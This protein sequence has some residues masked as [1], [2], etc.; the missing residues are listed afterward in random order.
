[1]PSPLELESIGDWS[2]IKGTEYHFV[3]ALWLLLYKKVPTVAFYQG[4]DL[5]VRPVFPPTLHNTASLV[6]LRVQQQNESEE[7]IWIQLK[8]T[9]K[10]WT[11]RE[12]QQGNLLANFLYNALLSE[13]ERRA[14]RIQLITQAPVRVEKVQDFLDNPT[15]HPEFAKHIEESI[16]EVQQNWFRTFQCSVE[17]TYLSGLLSRVLSQLTQTRPVHLDVLKAQIETQIACQ[18]PDPVGVREIAERLLGALLVDSARGPEQATPYTAQWIDQVVSF[19]LVSGTLLT[20]EPIQAATDALQASLPSS[21]NTRSFIAR[22]LADAAL[23]QFLSS[24]KTLFVLIG[25]SGIGKSWQVAHWTTQMLESHICLSLKGADLYSYRGAGSQELSTLVARKLRSYAPADWSEETILRRVLPIP[26]KNEGYRQFVIVIDDLRFPSNPDEIRIFL[27]YLGRL[28]EQCRDHKVKLVFSCQKHVWDSYQIHREI[29]SDDIFSLETA[30][31]QKSEHDKNVYSFLL[32]EYTYEE[33]QEVLRRWF[34]VNE[35]DH[36]VL[37]LRAPAFTA[38]RNPYI[39]DLYLKEHGAS[40]L[41]R[42]NVPSVDIDSLLKKRVN[43]AFHEVAERVGYHHEQVDVAFKALLHRL[44]EVRFTGLPSLQTLEILKVYIWENVHLVFQ[45]FRRVGL[46]S[47]ESSVRL[48]EPIVAD[49]LYAQ[50]VRDEIQRGVAICEELHPGADNGIVVALLRMIEDPVTYAKSFIENDS[51]WCTAVTEGL[52]HCSPQDYTVLAF[53]SVLSQPKTTVIGV[54]ACDALGQLASRGE[55]AWAWIEQMYL[56]DRTMERFRGERA[57]ASAIEYAPERVE[58]VIQQR[59][60]RIVAMGGSKPEKK[61]QLLRGVFDPLLLM[62]SPRVAA[63]GRRLLQRYGH[64]VLQDTSRHNQEVA[65]DLD[66]IRGRIALVLG[67]KE[68]QGLLAELQA[69]YPA[70]RCRAAYAVRPIVFEHPEEVQEALCEA[71]RREKDGHVMNRLLWSAHHLGEVAVDILVDAIE[72]NVAVREEPSLATGMTLAVLADIAHRCPSRVRKLLPARL[73]AHE[74]SLRALHSEMLAYAWWCCAQ[75]EPEAHAQL[76]SLTEA[77][78]TDVTPECRL[79]ALRGAA[80]AR[81]GVICLEQSVTS[82]ELLGRQSSYPLDTLQFFY[83]HLTDFIVSHIDVLKIHSQFGAWTSLLESC[84]REEEQVSVYPGSELRNARYLCA[85]FCKD[86]LYHIKNLAQPIWQDPYNPLSY[87]G[88]ESVGRVTEF[89][90]LI[91]ASPNDMFLT[92]DTSI[93]NEIDLPILYYWKEAATS[94]PSLLISRV[95]ARMFDLTPIEREEALELCEQMLVALT[96]FP[97]SLEQQQYK[98]VYTAIK[99][100]LQGTIQPSSILL[101]ASSMIEK[102]HAYALS[103]LI[104]AYEEQ[105]SAWLLTALYD[106]RGWWD[107]TRYRLEDTAISLGTHAYTIYTFPAVRLASIAVGQIFSY[108]DPAA[109]FMRA[110]LQ[111]HD[112]LKEHWRAF[113]GS[114]PVSDQ[115]LQ[116]TLTILEEHIQVAPYDERLWQYQGL[117]LLRLA[118]FVEAEESLQHCLSL[119]WCSDITRVDAYYNLGCVY[120]KM[121]KEDKCR[122]MLQQWRSLQPKNQF[123]YHWL[124]QDPDLTTM[125][126]KLWFREL[127]SEEDTQPG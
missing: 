10:P 28:I 102:T 127:Y 3:Y 73:T 119:S 33:V 74:P 93:R 121:G 124:T 115:N 25:P 7:D 41:R 58:T 30:E 78:L 26:R 31:T 64:L 36:I 122:D 35:I 103:L 110:R 90:Q 61:E 68:I 105:D 80:V 42:G 99:Q 111:I 5:L 75:H 47:T 118:R 22:P 6:P 56:S 51:R 65:R 27:Q 98:R 104:R 48:A 20:N 45:E 4:N 69:E 53:L 92:L 70:V 91:H 108:D 46:L 52:T 57:L 85:F 87:L 55:R 101:A 123:A 12:L 96:T 16:L 100:S 112:M 97:D 43:D 38:L 94:W 89:T 37:L 39:L 19:P 59:L 116:E 8:A 62:K 29:Q 1:M 117:M 71:I 9:E 40:L 63:V 24:S 120:A 72:E 14:W 50:Y 86:I 32:T 11:L 77:D 34:P 60:E 54:E 23:N 66:I 125:Q 106:K 79:F 13:R 67:K 49:Y 83:L 126:E 95:Y 88:L 44:W 109:Q 18:R 82:S 76:M 21:W 81:L 17:K 84:I 113:D 2:N 15:K 114:F 107:T